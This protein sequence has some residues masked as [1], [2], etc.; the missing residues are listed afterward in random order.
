MTARP[1]LICK[2]FGF[3]LFFEARDL[4]R[5][6]P[7]GA[8]RRHRLRLVGG[9]GSGALA[10]TLALAVADPGLVAIPASHLEWRLEQPWATTA[11]GSALASPRK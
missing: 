6:A 4:Q 9:T 5:I 8:L 10:V 1:K 11:D 3:L 7:F 2:R